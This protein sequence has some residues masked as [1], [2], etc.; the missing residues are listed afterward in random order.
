M[1]PS[2]IVS[3]TDLRVGISPGGCKQ[4]TLKVQA[5]RGLIRK[6]TNWKTRNKDYVDVEVEK[7]EK[8]EKRKNQ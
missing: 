7:M 4:N 2:K 5:E 8:K 3:N 1:H 6:I